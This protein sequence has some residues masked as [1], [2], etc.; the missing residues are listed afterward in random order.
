MIASFQIYSTTP[1][2]NLI[3]IV[4]ELTY[5]LVLSCIFDSFVLNPN[6]NDLNH[7]SI[8]TPKHVHVNELNKLC[9][10]RCPGG[11]IEKLSVDSMWYEDGRKIESVPIEYLNKKQPN[12]M[13][14][15]KLELKK[16]CPLLILKN[17]NVKDGITNG[18]R[19]ILLEVTRNLLKVKLCHNGEDALIPR[20]RNREHEDFGFV[21]ERLQ[22]PVMLAYAMTINKAQVLKNKNQ[23][24][25]K[26]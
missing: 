7:V 6:D 15:H 14:P 1:G 24:F 21:M 8:L 25:L 22:F 13:P 2:N 23:Q 12:G 26:T 10:D 9:L 16:F 18:T 5:Y 11:K 19:C 20:I 3:D 17:L 4:M